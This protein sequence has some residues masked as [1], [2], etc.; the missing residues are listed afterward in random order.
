MRTKLPLI[1]WCGKGLQGLWDPTSGMSPRWGLGV[2]MLPVGVLYFY[3]THVGRLV[4]PKDL[5]GR[6]SSALPLVCPPTGCSD[7]CASNK[8]HGNMPNEC[9]LVD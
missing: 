3:Q 9:C 4:P 6:I 5:F 2:A 1:N 8:L 7:T